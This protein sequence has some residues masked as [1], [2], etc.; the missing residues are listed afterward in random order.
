MP[1][2][3]GDAGSADASADVAAV[4]ADAES[5]L[6]VDG[7]SGVDGASP[8]PDDRYYVGGADASDSNPGTSAQPFATIQKCA[9]VAAPGDTCHI[10]AGVYRETVVPAVSGTAVAPITFAA[11]PGATVTID[12]TDPV[13]EWTL[14]TGNVYRSSVQLSGTAAEPYSSTEYPPDAELWANQVFVGTS[15]VPE[16]AY[17]QPTADPWSQAFV[18]GFSSTRSS[19]SSCMTPP[20]ATLLSGTVT[21]ASFPAFGV[22]TGA[23]VYFAGGWVA[24]SATVTGGVLTASN[25]TL[26]ISFPE[27]DAHVFPGGG[28]DNMFRLVG[29]RAFLTAANEWFY[30]PAATTLYFWP[31]AAGVP[32]DVFA[33]KRNYGFNLAGKAFINVSA[34]NLFATT[35]LTDTT[36][37]HVTLDGIRGQYL[38]QWQTAQYDSSLPLAGIYDANHRFDSGIVLHGTNHVLKNSTLHLSS[39]NGVT[40]LGSGTTVANN[41]I[42]DVGYGGTY[43]AAIAIE[44]GSH[45]LTI[46]NNTLYSTGRDVINMNTNLYPNPGYTNIH[47]AY[48]DISEYARIDH[49]LGGIYACCDTA[50]TG[51]RIDHNWIHDPANVGNGLHFDNGTYDVSVDHNVIWGL[52]GTGDV[53]HGGNGVNFGG[54]SNAPPPGSKLPYLKGVFYN[55]TIV[56]GLNETIFNYF[57]TAADDANMTVRNNILD[58]AQPAGQTF[59]Y[60]AGGAPVQDHNLIT[61][62]S[63]NGTGT[64]P[65]YTARATR[66]FTLL[67]ASPAINAGVILP[68]VTDGYVGSLPDEGAYEYGQSRWV[69][70]STIAP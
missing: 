70:G 64:N 40:I 32:T 28:N 35:I 60:V 6:A 36:S 66:D 20:C 47:I 23:T 41:T 68:G 27:S 26:S 45:D 17:P 22:M 16:A 69:A 65:M 55:N 38:S 48:N 15:A 62:Y 31:S 14:D 24:L 19:S 30:D 53:N 67:P 58:G 57:A 59:G 56:A 42:Y 12:G 51:S 49:D 5:N 8:L 46:T 9:T 18:G 3:L 52:K 54:H 10:N 50:L 44:V 13:G 33:K 2:S 11:V 29:K 21:Y 34:I 37:D 7:A 25:H 1:S 39:G 61:A 4:G 63:D 43:T